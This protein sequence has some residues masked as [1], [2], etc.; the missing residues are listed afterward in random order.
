MELKSTIFD[1]KITTPGF[2]TMAVSWY[3]FSVDDV[4]DSLIE[5]TDR[6]IPL[7]EHPTF[8][9]FREMHESYGTSVGLNLFFQKEIAGKIRTLQEVRDLRPELQES[10]SWL[11]FGPHALDF[12]T[13]PYDQT[14]AEQMEVFD[15]IYA[16]IDRFAGRDLRAEWVRLHYYS[17]SYELGAYFSSKGV[18]ALFSTD[19]PSGSHRMPDDTK[20]DLLT[21]GHSTYQGTNFVRTQFRIEFFVD[22]R[23]TKDDLRSLFRHSVE[24]YGYVTLYTHEYELVRPEIMQ[25]IRVAF[26]VLHESSIVSTLNV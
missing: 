20:K 25:M 18:Q 1:P 22:Q 9:L 5:V 26:R 7:F 21:I 2:G 23:V 12:D 16:E 3:H 8:A 17:E 4:F 6:N 10:G 24:K 13:A 19:R 11:K 14:P 15:R